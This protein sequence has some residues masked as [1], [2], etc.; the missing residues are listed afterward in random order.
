MPPCEHILVTGASSG[1][2]QALAVRLAAPDRHISLWGRNKDRLQETETLCRAKGASTALVSLDIRELEMSR[3]TLASLD[4]EHPVD[5]AILSAGISSGTK[6]DGT[7]ETAEDAC[8]TLACDLVATVNLAGTLFACMGTRR[9]GH[10]VFIS[11]IAALY[12]LPDSAAYGAAKA[13][14]A[15]YA[16]AMRA[17]LRPLRISLV[18][19]GY[20]DTPM[21]RRVAGPQPFRISAERAAAL[22]CDKLAAGRDDIIFP[23]PLALGMKLLTCLP[24]FLTDSF[25]Q[26]F[27]FTIRPD[28]EATARQS[29]LRGEQDV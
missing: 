4:A 16:K 13:G 26:R 8:R 11:S 6:P 14:L 5:M 19:P 24:S 2:G 22:I 7:L 1:L 12:P 27:A 21:S 23:W 18:Q 25:L 9:H 17:R 29:T 10:V 15:Y 20:V 28:E 3:N